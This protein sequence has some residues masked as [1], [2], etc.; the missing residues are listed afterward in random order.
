VTVSTTS[1]TGVVSTLTLTTHYSVTINADQDT[2]PGGAITLVSALATGWTAIITSSVASTQPLQLTS[3]GPFLPSVIE[4]A[5]DRVTVLVQQLEDGAIV[6]AR[7]LRAPAGETLPA[8]PADRA[9]KLLGFST[10]GDPVVSVMTMTALQRLFS[11]YY[12]GASALDT[13]LYVDPHDPLYGAVGDGI[14]DDASAINAALTAAAAAG[15]VAML[16]GGKTYRCAATVGL[17]AQGLALVGP[18]AESCTLLIDHTS[19]PGVSVSAPFCRIEGISVQAS[20]TRRAYTTSTTY[21][22]AAGLYGVQLYSASNSLTS[23][24]MREVWSIGHPSHG[25]YFGG[26]GVGSIL[27]QVA[28]YS[29]RGHGFFFDDRSEL[30]GTISRC[31]IVTMSE[32]RAVDNG[33]NALHADCATGPTYR[34]NVG[35]FETL[36]NAWN[37]SIS[38]LRNAEIVIGGE[39]HDITTPAM[40]DANGDARTATLHGYPRLPKT[41]LSS[42]L[43]IGSNSGPIAVWEPRFLSVGNGIVTASTVSGLALTVGGGTYFTQQALA[44]GAVNQG[45]AVVLGS[46]YLSADLDITPTSAVNYLVISPTAGGRVRYGAKSGTIVGNNSGVV[47]WDVS[48]YVSATIA[49]NSVNAQAARITLQTGAAADLV[50]IVCAGAGNPLPAGKVLHCFNGSSYTITLKH[51]ASAGYIRTKSGG[52]V[53]VPAGGRCSF[54][55][56]ASGN[57]WEL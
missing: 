13:R 35:N 9:D 19:G 43:Y 46:G 54:V 14:A 34:F 5:L 53:V 10:A 15:R 30:G 29:N 20:A 2:S 57:P 22:L 1:P 47:F 25:F 6:P 50:A 11:D 24:V 18:G 39:N 51:G 55:A 33:G 8:L 21:A 32:C 7:T 36:W 28:S 56:D 23:T 48:D 42:G 37:T 3:G 41:V 49:S 4:D 40:Y 44:G 31:G 52:D 45:A 38:G 12:S 17:A 26:E 27:E 16:R